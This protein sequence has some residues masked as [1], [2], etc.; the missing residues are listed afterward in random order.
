VFEDGTIVERRIPA[1]ARWVR[2]TVRYK[3]PLAHA[4]VDPERANPW[5]WNRLNDS[6]VL[7]TGEGAADTIGGRAAVKYGGLAAAL[8]AVWTQLLWALA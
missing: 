2:Y 3:S 6:K 1:E 5:D 4:V 8:S 7:G